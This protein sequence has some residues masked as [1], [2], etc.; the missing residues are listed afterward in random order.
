MPR[1]SPAAAPSTDGAV[2]LTGAT[3]FL[4][5][6]LLARSLERTD[7]T[8][9][10]L[11]RARDQEEADARL[12]SAASRVCRQPDAFNG[13]LGAAPADPEGEDMGIEPPRRD[14]LAEH[15]TQIVHAAA[16]VS[17]TLP[18]EQARRINVDG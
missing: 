13:R 17:F 18:L 2:L 16:S 9:C 7:R 3:G 15:T 14:E 4:G 10:A 11:V 12:R 1:S 6:E 5:M 8:V